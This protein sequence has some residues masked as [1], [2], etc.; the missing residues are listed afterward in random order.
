MFPPLNTYA[1]TPAAVL[2]IGGS[3]SPAYLRTSLDALAGVLPRARRIE[4]AGCGHL[5]P[6][7][8]GEPARVADEIRPFF[9]S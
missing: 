5:A 1:S 7:N 8:S 9:A 6:D 3:K 2:L 4:L